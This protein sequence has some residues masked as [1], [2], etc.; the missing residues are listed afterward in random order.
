MGWRIYA[1]IILVSLSFIDLTAT[2]HYISKYKKWQ[3]DKP[4]NLIEM[5]PLLNY[6]WE[7]LGFNLGMFVGSVIILA[8]IYIVSKEAHWIVV[9][10]LF[11]FLVF[12]MFNHYTNTNLLYQLI[13]KYP[14]GHL[15]E[16]TFGKVIGNNLK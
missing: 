4:Y 14:L 3:P 16:E 1:I 11:S 2:Y 5:N 13:E 15:P 6:L 12:S 7:K 9:A 10:L 8:L